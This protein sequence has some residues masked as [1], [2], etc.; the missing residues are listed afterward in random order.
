MLVLNVM[1]GF[2]SAE[3]VSAEAVIAP[4]A[5]SVSNTFFICDD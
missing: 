1:A 2:S 5:I 4:K 3:A